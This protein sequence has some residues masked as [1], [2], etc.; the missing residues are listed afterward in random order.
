MK[1]EIS[2]TMMGV[3]ITVSV[4]AIV[5]IGWNMLGSHKEDVS[6]AQQMKMM[7]GLK[8]PGGK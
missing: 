4:L 6:P 8:P 3:I 7:N 1:K 5:L 2:P